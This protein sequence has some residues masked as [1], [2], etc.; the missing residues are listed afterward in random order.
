MGT[1]PKEIESAT[2][3]SSERLLRIAVV[4]ETYP[5]EVNGVARTVARAVTGL[6]TRGHDVQVVRP[7]QSDAD[8]AL[9]SERYSE[10]LTRGLPIPRYPELK[11]GLPARRLLSG[12]WSGHRPDVVHIATEGPLG[13]SALKA[14]KVLGVPVVS[15]F[16]T[17]FDSYSR[18]Y[19]V[20]L[21]RGVIRNFLC[22]FHNRTACT[23]VP[24][25]ALAKELAEA[26]FHNLEVVARGV[27]TL[28]FNPD[29][30]SESLRRSWAADRDTLVA[31]HVGR[32][33][34]EKNLDA[35][36]SAFG[37]M[38]QVNPGMKF[39]LVGDGPSRAGLQAHCPEAVF[40]GMRSGED[41]AA[42][43][44]SADLMLFP[45]VT[46]TYGNVTPEAMA[47]G[48]GVVAFDYAAAS[49]LIR[50]GES[51]WLAPLNDMTAYLRAASEAA[52]DL[53]AARRIGAQARMAVR[54]LD[55]G[56]IVSQIESQY[57]KAIRAAREP[58]PAV[59]VGPALA[60]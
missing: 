26:G 5:P 2:S 39:V 46:E 17:N 57:H 16:R 14:A 9:S 31:I 32:L 13:W 11:V 56:Q 34:P 28:L 21:L 50:H 55:W 30:R 54:N 52:T 33:A 36:R 7:R 27:D 45:S 10:V 3:L 41:L 58:E 24:T 23:M 1:S 4:T 37:S 35:L 8:T 38:R 49:Q 20:G 44:A 59:L 47:S 53:G 15:E 43:Y 29:R 25:A 42:H 40:V 18:Y 12:L 48:L 6:R 22:A 60:R 19:G 51:G